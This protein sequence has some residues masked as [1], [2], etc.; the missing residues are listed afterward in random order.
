MFSPAIEKSVVSSHVAPGAGD[1]LLGV[2]HDVGDQARARERR[3]REQRGGREA[4]G[5]GDEA[6]LAIG[7]R[8]SS[9]R[10]YDGL[11]DQLRPRVLPYQCS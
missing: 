11:G 1:A 4:A 9:V 8:W 5:V 7:S 10:P 6:A 3:E 2:D